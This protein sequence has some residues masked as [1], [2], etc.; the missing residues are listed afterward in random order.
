MIGGSFPIDLAWPWYDSF[1]ISV[2]DL[3][4]GCLRFQVEAVMGDVRLGAATLY[5]AQEIAAVEL[6]SRLSGSNR[7]FTS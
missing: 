7:Q 4:V 5:A 6:Q 1:G 3:V 2:A